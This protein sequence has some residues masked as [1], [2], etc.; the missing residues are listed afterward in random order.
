[1][2]ALTVIPEASR[3]RGSATPEL[4]SQTPYEARGDRDAGTIHWA[5]PAGESDPFLQGAY[6]ALSWALS[7]VF[8]EALGGLINEAT[9]SNVERWN[10]STWV[11]VS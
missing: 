3:F 4:Y 11:P 6:W 9:V 1:M 5:N 7:T 10:G 8:G 2:I